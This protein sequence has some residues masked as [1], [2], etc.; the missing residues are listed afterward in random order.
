MICACFVL[1]EEELMNK[2]FDPGARRIGCCLRLIVLARQPTEHQLVSWI[3]C[4]TFWM[5][6]H[7]KTTFIQQESE[8]RQIL[9]KLDARPTGFVQN[10]FPSLNPA[11]SSLAHKS[12]IFAN[13]SSS[14]LIPSKAA[15]SR[16]VLLPPDLL[17][18]FGR[19]AVEC[20]GHW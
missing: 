11:R 12:R 1:L 15:N 19:P 6:T 4:V 9:S 10:H 3:C 2:V 18:D 17:Y 16:G 5:S 8:S 14:P 7:S 20:K 13:Q